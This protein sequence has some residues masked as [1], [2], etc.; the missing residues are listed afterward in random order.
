MVFSGEGQYIFYPQNTKL[1]FNA[2]RHT[3]KKMF[4]SP[5][6]NTLGKLGYLPESLLPW[7]CV[8]ADLIN[9]S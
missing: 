4:L 8:G 9:V 6:T 1:P 7:V 2:S 5:D 3:H